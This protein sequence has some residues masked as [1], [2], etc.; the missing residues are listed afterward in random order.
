MQREDR[1]D[2]S[3]Q[4]DVWASGWQGMVP[5]GP[6]G[7]SLPPALLGLAQESPRQL[8]VQGAQREGMRR[9]YGQRMNG[10]GSKSMEELSPAPALFSATEER[11]VRLCPSDPS[12]RRRKCCPPQGPKA[13]P[14]SCSASM[15]SPPLGSPGRRAGLGLL[16]ERLAEGNQSLSLAAVHRCQLVN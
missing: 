15:P 10:A 4:L 9:R 12:S 5:R 1:R 14:C 6:R 3:S 16:G 13:L 8:W 2:G 11:P 7:S